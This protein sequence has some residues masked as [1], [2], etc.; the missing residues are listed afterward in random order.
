MVENLIQDVRYAARI[1]V[2]NPVFTMVA[3][4]TL[5][6]GIGANT[7]IFSLVNA[8]LVRPLPFREPGNLVWITNPSG[9]VQGIP[10]MN[11]RANVKDWREL[12][13]SFESLGG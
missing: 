7:A 2:K 6:L 5:A 1:L 3:V 9:G 11:R 13:Q 8:L 10:G 12:S 4:M